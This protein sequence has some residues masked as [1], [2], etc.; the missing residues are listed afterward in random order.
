[1]DEF[2][3]MEVI[4]KFMVKKCLF[5]ALIMSASVS[6]PMFNGE[7]RQAQAT[8]DPNDPVIQALNFYKCANALLGAGKSLYE[9][10]KPV[11]GLAASLD[12]DNLWRKNNGED[13]FLY[14]HRI[15]G[16]VTKLYGYSLYSRAICNKVVG[17]TKKFV[18]ES[19]LEDYSQDFS[20]VYGKGS[21]GKTIMFV[22]H[23]E[24]WKDKSQQAFMKYEKD[25]LEEGLESLSAAKSIAEKAK[26]RK[27]LLLQFHPDK[28][29]TYKFED[30]DSSSVNYE[31]KAKRHTLYTSWI[32]KIAIDQGVTK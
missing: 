27:R 14:A 7:Q 4:M 30:I 5:A 31:L 1:M 15:L 10:V 17:K 25:K 26:I 28:A 18:K 13:S 23:N 2:Q 3:S 16:E 32:N 11:F 9:V 20:S 29:R 6:L 12:G 8:L 24:E 22:S 21:V 19:I